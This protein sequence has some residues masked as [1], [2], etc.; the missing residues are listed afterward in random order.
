MQIELIQSGLTVSSRSKLVLVPVLK[1]QLT[2]C[3]CDESSRMLTVTFYLRFL[4]EVIS[5]ISSTLSPTVNETVI[6][7]I[8]SY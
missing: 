2:G 5:S 4:N 3:M 6:V 8:L 7:Y 1:T